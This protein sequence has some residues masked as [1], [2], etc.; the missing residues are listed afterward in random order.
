M[1]DNVIRGTAVNGP[2]ISHFFFLPAVPN[3]IMIIILIIIN[4]YCR[5][6]SY[7]DDGGCCA[8][9]LSL[10]VQVDVTNRE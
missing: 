10:L 1:F 5:T 6:K 9:A 7:G 8:H 3:I 2:L 4:R